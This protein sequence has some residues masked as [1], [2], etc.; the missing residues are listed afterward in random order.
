MFLANVLVRMAFAL[1]PTQ[2]IFVST[3]GP[4]SSI[5]A[6]MYLTTD[7][8]MPPH[9]P[10]SDDM[11]MTR[12]LGLDLSCSISAFSKK[13]LAPAPYWRAGFSSLSALAYLAADTIF[14][15]F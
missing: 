4:S 13:A 2:M 6:L 14:M 8:W 1:S 7:E 10:R 11:A 12:W 5:I 9:R 15:D 3:F